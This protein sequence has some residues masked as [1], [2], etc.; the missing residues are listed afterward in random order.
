MRIKLPPHKPAPLWMSFAVSGTSIAVS[1]IALVVTLST[2]GCHSVKTAPD[3]APSNFTNPA[4]SLL[5]QNP[6]ANPT[7]VGTVR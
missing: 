6:S 5:T 7:S 2:S 4:P 3:P 1:V